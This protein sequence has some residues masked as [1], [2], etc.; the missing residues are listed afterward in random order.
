MPEE[1]S[2]NTKQLMEQKNW[3]SLDDVAQ[4]YTNLETKLGTNPVNI[5]AEGDVDGWKQFYT[6]IG[7]PDSYTYVPEEGVT[8]DDNL[9][10]GF[11][12]VAKDTG[13]TQK[14]FDA[15]VN[16]QVK[17][18]KALASEQEQSKTEQWNKTVAECEAALKKDWGADVEKRSAAASAVAEKL[19]LSELFE[20]KG[21][22]NDATAMKALDKLARMMSEDSLRTSTEAA[23][24]PSVEDELKALM[25]SKEW[26]DPMHPKHNETQKRYL[27][28][29]KSRRES[30]G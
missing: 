16:Y 21:L 30:R 13:L 15:A 10:G 14:Q 11:K 20:K 3:T 6:Q 23:G 5:P 19:G 29:I 18:G 9:L 7:C 27:E 12:Q 8:I 24:R 17:I 22:S 1:M 26:L 25:V 2:D 28:L 4:G